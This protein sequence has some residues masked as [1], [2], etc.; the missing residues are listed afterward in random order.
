MR[1]SVCNWNELNDI[2]PIYKIHPCKEIQDRPGFWVAHRGFPIPGTGFRISLPVD[3][4][5]KILIV[6]GIPDY[7]ELHSGFQ[8]PGF[9]IPQAKIARIRES[10]G[11][12]FLY[13]GFHRQKFPGF[14]NPDSLTWGD[15]KRKRFHNSVSYYNST[16]NRPSRL[17]RKITMVHFDHF[18]TTSFLTGQD[19][20]YGTCLPGPPGLTGDWYS[21][22]SQINLKASF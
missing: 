4:G 14:G 18:Y 6:R 21:L 12:N 8:R 17:I 13:S 19:G 16:R 15:K 1:C 7:L 2:G 20:R 9:Q 11:K 3:L 10:T 5:F 22:N